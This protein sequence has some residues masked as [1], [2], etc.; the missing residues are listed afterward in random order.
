MRGAPT[1][2][3]TI[4]TGIFVRI[5]AEAACED[6]RA[7]KSRITPYWRVIRDD[8]RL[9]EKLPG[10]PAAQ[11]DH[12]AAEGHALETAGKLRVKDPARSLVKLR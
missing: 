4:T 9:F 11:A 6:A 2:P 3:A 8:G 5:A 10:G 7:G 1:S 12:L